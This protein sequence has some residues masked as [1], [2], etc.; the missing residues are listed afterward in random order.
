MLATRKFGSRRLS[1]GNANS[2]CG[3]CERLPLA[4]ISPSAISPASATMRF[5]SAASTIGGSE[6]S[7][8]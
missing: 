1:A 8:S 2:D 4:K 5:R 3:M 7:P 6:P